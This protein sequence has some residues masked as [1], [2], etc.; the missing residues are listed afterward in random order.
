MGFDI[1]IK[2]VVV[3]S[4]FLTTI[5]AIRENQPTYPLATSVFLKLVLQVVLKVG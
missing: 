5:K 2:E 1:Y 4:V 3:G